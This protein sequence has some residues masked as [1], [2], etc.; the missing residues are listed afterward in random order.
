MSDG[1][2]GSFVKWLIVIFVVVPALIGTAST[3]LFCRAVKSAQPLAGSSGECPESGACAAAVAALEAAGR[4]DSATLRGVLAEPS[5]LDGLPPAAT[6]TPQ[7]KGQYYL[8]HLLGRPARS[9]EELRSAPMQWRVAKTETALDGQ[10][11]KVRVELRNLP[12][13]A[14]MGVADLEL[15]RV[16]D[17]WK[18]L[19]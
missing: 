11:A 12:G 13:Q 7:E 19:R 2:G 17:A 14:E 6:T 1:G 3:F 8:R 10:T 5:W 15:A 18:L 4:A 16:G 9:L